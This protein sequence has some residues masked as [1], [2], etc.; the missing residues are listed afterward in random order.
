MVEFPVVTVRL[1]DAVTPTL[2]SILA[3][4]VE[5]PPEIVAVVDTD[6]VPDVCELKVAVCGDAVLLMLCCVSPT[7]VN[8]LS[9]ERTSKIA[10]PPQTPCGLTVSADA[11]AVGAARRALA[12]PTVRMVRSVRRVLLDVC[13][14][15]MVRSP[16][17]PDVRVMP[18]T[19]NIT[20]W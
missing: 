4:A 1:S 10:S 20:F 6:T 7:R 8:V 18:D 15:L 16:L 14:V 3:K 11:A 9:E 19:S 13:V 17:V 5:I 2:A 12:A